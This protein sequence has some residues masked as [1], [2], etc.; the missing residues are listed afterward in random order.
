MGFRPR[1]AGSRA[2]TVVSLSL[3]PGIQRLVRLGESQSGSGFFPHLNMHL[4]FSRSVGAEGPIPAKAQREQK[5]WQLLRK[6]EAQPPNNKETALSLATAS[7]V[8]AGWGGQGA[9]GLESFHRLV[10]TINPLGC[11]GG[12]T[13]E[14]S[15][16]PA[17]WCKDSQSQSEPVS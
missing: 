10:G 13:Q 16:R 4:R 12:I 6:T 14:C 8:W 15:G 3:F 7:R 2:H 5:L 9:G 1:L 17:S 11:G